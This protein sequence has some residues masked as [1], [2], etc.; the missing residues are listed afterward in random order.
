[1]GSLLGAVAHD[2]AAV[3]RGFVEPTEDEREKDREMGKGKQPQLLYAWKALY[4]QTRAALETMQSE[5]QGYFDERSHTWQE[6]EKGEAFQEILDR[7]EETRST[8]DDL[9][10]E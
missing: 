9:A 8:L 10:L 7:V 3:G 4:E 1:M 6:G 5:M 2:S